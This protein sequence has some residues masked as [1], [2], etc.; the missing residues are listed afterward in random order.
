MDLESESV[1]Q[2][3]LEYL[4]SLE[5]LTTDDLDIEL[6]ESGRMFPINIFFDRIKS[7]LNTFRIYTLLCYF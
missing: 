5:D 3:N 2:E 7:A 1:Y 6:V 4:S